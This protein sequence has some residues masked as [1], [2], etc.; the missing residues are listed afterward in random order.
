MHRLSILLT[1]ALL[2]SGFLFGQRSHTIS[3]GV[4]TTYYYGDLTDQF[5]NALVRPGISAYYQ[6]YLKP[7]MGL[8]FGLTHGTIGASDAQAND[9]TRVKRNLHFRSPLTELSAAFVFEFIKDKDFGRSWKQSRH[10]TPYAFSGVALF[11]FRPRA[12]LNGEWIE[13]QP[14]GT[15]GQYAGSQYPQPYKL[16]QVSL[17]F[18]IGLS[19]RFLPQWGINLEVAYRKTFTDFL[20][21]VSTSYA[22]PELLLESGGQFAPLLSNRSSDF[23]Q[24]GDQRGNPE[25]KDSYFFSMFS[26]TYYL[27]D[28]Y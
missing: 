14:L 18:G 7:Q 23:F 19:Y 22:E 26:L 1:F 28:R 5:N 21:D 20:D 9:P 27:I 15:E 16:L 4:G 2:P 8:R 25:Q 24:A 6:G 10:F 12:E 11:A 3:I 17:P 13:L